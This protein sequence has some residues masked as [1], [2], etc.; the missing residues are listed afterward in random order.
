M[1]LK[2]FV[3][4]YKNKSNHQIKFEPKKKELKKVNLEIKDILNLEIPLN[5]KLKKF[6][7]I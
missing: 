4:V 2:D 3:N 5:K 1:K 7:E 6:N